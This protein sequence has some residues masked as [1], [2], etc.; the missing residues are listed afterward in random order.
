MLGSSQRW[1]S[2]DYNYKTYFNSASGL[3]QNMAIQYKGF[4][5]GHVKSIR[6]AEDDRVEVQFT[7]F[8][9]YID[10]V[11]TGSLVEIMVSPIGGLVGNQ[12]LFHPGLG[13][14]I[15]PE[16]ETIPAANSSEGKR[17]LASGL[18]KR[19]EA[20]DD[21]SVIMNRVGTLL[22]TFNEIAADVQEAFEGS[23]RTSL[24]RT[25][26]DLELA[27]AG[28]MNQMNP[29]LAHLN[30]LTESLSDPDGTVMTILDSDG[31]VY[32]DLAELLDSLSGTLRN[33]EKTSD[34]FPSQVGGALADLHNALM[35]VQDILVAVANNP[36]L[37]GGIPRRTETRA[38][39]AHAR[40]AE[41]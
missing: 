1:F 24:G 23:D 28:I 21:I 30:A 8:D 36:L 11:R 22:E 14:D 32:S 27:M 17:L 37:K 20:T 3:S 35:S 29:I 19:P 38:G 6:L 25:F 16:G 33:V 18:A 7:I 12:F 39:G 13:D 2:R 26:G 10:R 15:I 5:I 41:F 34:Y 9:T 40:E 31:K 4:T